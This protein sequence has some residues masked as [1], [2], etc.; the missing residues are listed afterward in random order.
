MGCMSSGCL[1]FLIILFTILKSE[2]PEAWNL[3]YP[4]IS[5]Y[6]FLGDSKLRVNSSAVKIASAGERTPESNCLSPRTKAPRAQGRARRPIRTQGG[7]TYGKDINII[8]VWSRCKNIIICSAL[9]SR[10]MQFSATCRP[11][12]SGNQ[13]RLHWKKIFFAEFETLHLYHKKTRT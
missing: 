3:G 5:P 8:D 4:R 11:Q 12:E 13:F 10:I 6:I 1:N 7:R 9:Y 2:L